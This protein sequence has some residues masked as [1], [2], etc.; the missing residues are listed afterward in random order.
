[1][2]EKGKEQ[3][4]KARQVAKGFVHQLVIEFGETFAPMEGLDIIGAVI[5]I[6]A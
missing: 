6:V 2:N 5:S 4:H 3:K 1:L